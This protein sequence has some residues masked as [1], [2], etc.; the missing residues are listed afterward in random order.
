MTLQFGCNGAVQLEATP[1]DTGCV[2]E[3]ERSLPNY[4]VSLKCLASV[5]RDD[6]RVIS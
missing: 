6:A 2:P 1:V 4:I 3:A 5:V